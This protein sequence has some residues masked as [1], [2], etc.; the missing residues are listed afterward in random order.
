MLCA[1][2]CGSQ[3][4]QAQATC[5]GAKKGNM[6]KRC[7][8][9]LCMPCAGQVTTSADCTYTVSSAGTCSA[10]CAAE[11]IHSCMPFHAAQNRDG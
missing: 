10:S 6:Y 2:A 1:G 9:H 3:A 11:F 7:E 8:H 5:V 4:A